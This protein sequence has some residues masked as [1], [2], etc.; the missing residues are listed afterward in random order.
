[1][2]IYAAGCAVVFGACLCAAWANGQEQGASKS[3]N[4]H[5][6]VASTVPRGIE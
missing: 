1:L 4:A 3:A 5:S 2:W 6:E